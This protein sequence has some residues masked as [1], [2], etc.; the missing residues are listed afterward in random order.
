MMKVLDMINYIPGKKIYY[1]IFLL[2][3]FIPYFVIVF[4]CKIDIPDLKLHISF[5]DDFLAAQYKPA[6]PIFFVLIKLFSFFSNNYDV[7]L[8]ASALIFS[9]AQFFTLHFSVRIIREIFNRELNVFM[10]ILLIALQFAMPIPFFSNDIR[11]NSLSMNY[12]HNGTLSSSVPFAYAL[13]LYSFKF[14]LHDNLSYLKKAYY[15]SFLLILTKPSFTFCFIPV[16]PFFSYLKYGFGTKLLRSLQLSTFL[17]FGIIAQSLYL[18]NYTPS[19]LKD[20]K[21]LFQPFYLYGSLENHIRIISEGFLVG[22]FFLTLY[23]KQILK[24]NY[25]IFAA[26]SVLL[27]YSISFTMIDYLNGLPFPNMSWQTSIMNK[28]AILF[29]FPFIV[30]SNPNTSYSWKAILV[31][32]ILLIHAFFGILYLY[33]VPYYKVFHLNF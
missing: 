15:L 30:P 32:I 17:T 31:S 24:D 21:I 22:I 4:F 29:C 23:F 7:K 20:F 11:Y 12:F 9:I 8:F 2:V 1:P 19:Y 25:L 33:S 5:S 18:K 6:H 28:L 16:F 13:C 27:G 14:L 10:H 26:V 3:S